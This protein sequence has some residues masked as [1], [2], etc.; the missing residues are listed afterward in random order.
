MYGDETVTSITIMAS[1]D[2]M[3]EDEA[4]EHQYD[5]SDGS[6]GQSS[7]DHV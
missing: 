4:D 3:I 1:K 6:Y 7:R 2:S 5:R